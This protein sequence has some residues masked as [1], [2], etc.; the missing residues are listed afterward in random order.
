[1]AVERVDAGEPRPGRADRGVE[2]A[3]RRDAAQARERVARLS[4]ER[5][6][7]PVEAAELGEVVAEVEATAGAVDEGDA[8]L[9]V[10]RRAHHDRAGYAVRRA[11][12]PRRE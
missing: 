9:D 10:H 1:P 7:S 3:H 12:A 2:R 5:G 8:P 6:L 4:E 11:R